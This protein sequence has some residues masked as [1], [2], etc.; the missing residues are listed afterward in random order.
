MRFVWEKQSY[1][2]YSARVGPLTVSIGRTAIEPFKWF[3]E[4]VFGAHVPSRNYGGRWQAINAAERAADAALIKAVRSF[5]SH[6]E[7]GGTVDGES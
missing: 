2:R 5:D 6:P 3:V 1:K 7:G 4:S